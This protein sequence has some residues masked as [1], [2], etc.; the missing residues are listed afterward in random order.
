MPTLTYTTWPRPRL[1]RS[2]GTYLQRSKESLVADDNANAPLNVQH[3][4]NATR[5]SDLCRQVPVYHPDTQANFTRLASFIALTKS[6]TIQR[7]LFSIPA[8]PFKEPLPA[9]S[10]ERTFGLNVTMP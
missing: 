6:D 9:Y 5:D 4:V 3:A 8:V 1:Y 7:V 2:T 10:P